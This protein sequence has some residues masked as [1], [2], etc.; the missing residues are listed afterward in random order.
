[1]ETPPPRKPRRALWQRIVLWAA[2]GIGVL[3]V[4]V[5]VTIFVLL[6]NTSFHRYVLRTAQVK[7]S[8][9]IGTQVRLRE[10]A[11]HFSGISPSLDLYNVSVDGAVPYRNPPLLTAD[12]INVKLTVTS[13]LRRT[14]YVDNIALDHPVVRV[15]IDKQGKNNLP[16]PQKSSSSSQTNVFDLGIRHAMLDRGEVYYN[17]RKSLL[18]A[19]VHDLTF[20][21]TYALADKSYSG[22]L[23]YRNGHVKM[24][25]WNP[26]EHDFQ[27]EFTAT[28]QAFTVKRAV[29]AAG[30]SQ[31]LLTAEMSD[32]TQPHVNATY[33]ATVNAGQFRALMKNPSLPAGVLRAKGKL[34]YVSQPNR[35]MLATLTLDGDL[36][37]SALAVKTPSLNAVIRDVSARYSVA[38]GDANVRDIRAHLLGGQLTAELTMRDLAGNTHSQVGAALRNLS[39]AQL[40]NAAGNAS[41]NNVALGGTANATSNA[42]WGKTMDDL[43]AHADVTINASA[44]PASGGASLPVNGVVHAIYRAPGSQ[45]TLTDSYLRTPQTAL[46]LNG[47]ISTHSALAV[48]MHSN[49]LHELDAVAADFRTPANGQPAPMGLYGVADFNG[50]V[51]GTTAAPHITGQLSATNLRVHGSSWKLL[52]T[53]IDASPSAASLQNGELDPADRGRI[54]FNL[55]AGLNHWAFSNTSPIQVGFNA[56]QVNIA[57]LNKLTGSTA[58]VSGT[59]AANVAISG[60]ELDPAGHGN[61]ALSNAKISGEPVQSLNLKF[62]GNGNEVHAD[63]GL[64]LP[65]AG[66]ADAVLTYFPK[67]QTYE[68]TLRSGGIKLDQ[69]ET[70]KQRNMDLHGTL[71]LDASGRGSIHNPELQARLA[72]P[73]LVMRGQTINGVSLT[74]NVANHLANFALDSNVLNT[75]IRSRGTIKLADDYVADITLDTQRIEFAPLVAAFMP[76]QAGS[77]TGQTELHATLRGPLKN[78][79]AVE[80]HIV[81]PQLAM[82]YKNAVQLAA[83]G[84]IRADYTRGVL[85]LQRSAIRG[86]GT[87]LQFQGR[88]PVA[89]RSAPMSLLL[90]GTVD[91]KL[92]QLMDPDIASSGQLRFNINSYGSAANADVQGQVQVVNASFATG[93]MPLGIQNGNGVLTLTKDRLNISS[94]TANVGGGTLRAAGGIVYRPEL[95]FD[96]AMNGQDIRL[97]YPAGV[98]SASDVNIA[99]TGTLQQALLNGKVTVNQ[100][101][102]TPDFDVT[103]LMSS[104]GGETTP[105]PAQGFGQNLQL[106]IGVT[107]GTGINLVSRTLSVAGAA[108]LRVAGTAAQPVILGRI[109]LSGGDLIVLNNRYVLQGGTIDFVDPTRT[110]PV[111]NVSASTRINQYNIQLRFW[112]PADHLHTNYASDPA[113]PPSDIINLIAFGKTSEA[114][115]ANPTPP[116]SLG[117]ESLVASQVSSQVTNRI[118][119]AAGISQLSIDPVL[120]GNGESPGARIAIQQR[121]TSKIFV[122]FAADV[123][124]TQN[125]A[126]KLEYQRSPRVSISA[127]RDQNG[128]FAVDTK[129]RK[130]GRQ[131]EIRCWSG[132]ATQTK[133]AP[134]RLPEWMLR[135]HF[136][137]IHQA[138]SV[139][140]PKH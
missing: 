60:T 96:L 75:G 46:E 41:M 31:V 91:L 39:L 12:H 135:E 133:T 79:A 132:A 56:S 47:T 128:G 26:L 111:M 122:T 32:Y 19:D 88:V 140:P 58:P 20:R 18:D 98:R 10:Y 11:L 116:G 129:I 121:V 76:T 22:S 49:D 101:S 115:A 123:T 104:V 84:P 35:P 103:D 95:R 72:I 87:D 139:A 5:V 54:T 134:R 17:D 107:S 130:P 25:T 15:F 29:L 114:Q 57:N 64:K 37:S 65:Q 7:A 99:L 73:Q 118:E 71:N 30:P 3:I 43:V 59:L 66:A 52:R 4:L 6:H 9:A 106:N 74:A 44:A 67:R 77:I 125:Q 48:R 137:A 2:A 127:T 108:N 112:G 83:A 85:Q 92:A 1:M 55:R 120:G 113:L 93:D 78:K 14:W 40:K 126:I 51:T 42:V 82:D 109:N 13:L 36:N 90:Q 86:T 16:T 24:S 8:A 34:Q 102:F 124:S 61:V 138:R 69:L 94:F 97:L 21:S 63:L 136:R 131:A 105:P 119:K 81:V 38:H 100:L 80:A 33:D 53:N 45:I 117:A 70:I 27:A 23:A 110:Q 89:D 68:A 62:D 28:P 50:S